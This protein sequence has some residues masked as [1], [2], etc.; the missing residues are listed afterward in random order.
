[1]RRITTMGLCVIAMFATGALAAASAS[2]ELPEYKTCVKAAKVGKKYTG[3][4]NDKTCSEVNGKGEGKYELGEWNAG[5]K[6][7]FVGK[8]GATTFDSYRPASEA[9]PWAGGTTVNTVTCTSGKAEGELIGPKETNETIEF[10]G[11]ASEGEKCAS[12]GAKAG[13][14]K[15]TQIMTKLGYVSAED[16]P[17]KPAYIG[18]PAVW[19]VRPRPVGGL[20]PGMIWLFACAHLGITGVGSAVSIAGGNVNV[21]SKES[22]QTLTVGATGGQEF[23]LGGFGEAGEAHFVTSEIG[24]VQFPSGIATTVTLKGEAIEIQA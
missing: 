16:G 15:T 18:N 23:P 2:A 10:K 8:T 5:K 1:M 6:V 24:G 3:D 20:G 9:E 14:I 13:T 7:T 17:I 19:F 4:Y 22:T 21:V 11:C 12:E